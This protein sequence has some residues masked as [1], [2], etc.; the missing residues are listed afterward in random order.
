MLDNFID[1]LQEL[2]FD[3]DYDCRKCFLKNECKNDAF[4]VV[5]CSDKKTLKRYLKKYLEGKQ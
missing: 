2:L 1:I 4:P 5:I 3:A